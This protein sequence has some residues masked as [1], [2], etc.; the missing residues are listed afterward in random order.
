MI[1]SEMDTIKTYTD[2]IKEEAEVFAMRIF[3]N[4]GKII[5]NDVNDF[6]GSL[7]AIINSIKSENGSGVRRHSGG[8]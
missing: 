4:G 2:T 8:V 3:Y 5:E 6:F 1:R 7:M